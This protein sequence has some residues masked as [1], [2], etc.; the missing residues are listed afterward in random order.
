M[1]HVIYMLFAETLDPLLES[2]ELTDHCHVIFWGEPDMTVNVRKLY[3]QTV[4]V[5]RQAH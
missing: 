2:S 4:Q 1:G 3:P 5:N